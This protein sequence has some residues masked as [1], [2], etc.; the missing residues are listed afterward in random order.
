M[1]LYFGN[2]ILKKHTIIVYI[3]YW[4]LKF[5]VA[6]F[7]ITSTFSLVCTNKN[8]KLSHLLMFWNETFMQ[9]LE[10]THK[11]ATSLWQK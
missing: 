9:Y 10:Q 11:Y 3:M 2:E 1:L 4:L 8:T 5:V 7:N 6:K